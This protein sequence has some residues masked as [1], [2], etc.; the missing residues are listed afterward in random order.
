MPNII[1]GKEGAFQNGFFNSDSGGVDVLGDFETGDFSNWTTAGNFSSWSVTSTS[2]LAG[3]FSAEATDDLGGSRNNDWLFTGTDIADQRNSMIYT[4]GGS[5]AVTIAA[6]YVDN[7]NFYCARYGGNGILY[8]SK[9]VEGSNT[10]LGSTGAERSADNNMIVIEA[11]GTS[12][13]A[14]IRSLDG[15]TLLSSVSTADSD[16]SSGKLAFG[17]VGPALGSSAYGPSKMDNVKRV[18]L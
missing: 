16:I 3:S 14:E 10:T 11:V 13:K 6:R 4:G 2:P 12:I 7:N 18:A 9:R 1:I 17:G 15:T 5:Y 8:L